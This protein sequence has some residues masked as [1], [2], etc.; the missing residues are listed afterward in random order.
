M[1]RQNAV[2]GGLCLLLGAWLT[3]SLVNHPHLEQ[4][5]DF[6]AARLEQADYQAVLQAVNDDF[7]AIQTAAGQTPAPAANELTVARRL[8]LAL[9]GTIPSLEEIRAIEALPAEHQREWWLS[10][11]LEDRR[12]ADYTA[13][14]FARAFVGTQ[15]GP[16][17]VFRRRRFASW[18][19]DQLHENRPYDELV[20]ELVSG[21]GLWTDSPAVNFVTVTLDEND[22]GRPDPIRLAART[23]RAF[24]GMRID[25]LQCH[26][27]NLGTIELGAEDDLR[28]GLQSDFHQLAAFYSEAKSSLLGVRDEPQEYQYQYLDANEEQLVPPVPPFHN[29]LLTDVG[30]RRERLADWLTHQENKPF[31]RAIVNRVWALLFGKPLVEPIDDIPLG[32]ELPASLDILAE[33]FVTH[34][35][36]LRRLIRLIA[37][38]NVFGRESRAEVVVT[39]EFERNWAVFPLTRLR[40]EQMAGA[41]IQAASVKTIDADS[42]I[43]FRLQ[44]FGEESEFIKRY[45]DT[46]ED[47]FDSRAGTIAQRLLV[48]NGKLVKERTEENLVGNASTRIAALA[49]SDEQAVELAYLAVLTREPSQQERSHFAAALAQSKGNRRSEKMEDLYWVLV[50]STEFSWNH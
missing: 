12:F 31:G 10:R 22:D 3:S 1:W 42:H 19:S 11:I 24:L 29:E 34:G 40:P 9:M 5:T 36:D 39:P 46:G 26:D 14:R 32:T 20:R 44:R 41:A 18:L 48:M 15:D 25:C 2:F 13:E 37:A 4:P 33:D 50:N 6:Q 16:F 38:T 28:G 49:P 8:S 30:S 35:Y 43:I 7:H 47:E 21:A 23:S 45:G 27:D 17:L